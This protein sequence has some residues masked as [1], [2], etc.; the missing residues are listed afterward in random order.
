[1]SVGITLGA[2]CTMFVPTAASMTTLATLLFLRGVS[3]GFINTG[4]YYQYTGGLI[5]ALQKIKNITITENKEYN[6]TNI[7]SQ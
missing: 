3:E 6:N 4:Q 1:M 2:V 5:H 7:G